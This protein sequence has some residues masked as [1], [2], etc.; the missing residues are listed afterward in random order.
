MNVENIVLGLYTVSIVFLLLS[1]FGLR[2]LFALTWS[3]PFIF[4]KASL[5]ILA[6]LLCL[7]VAQQLSH[8][9][10]VFPDKPIVN[11]SVNKLQDNQYRLK[12]LDGN[13]TQIRNQSEPG[14]QGEVFLINGDQW[15]LEMRM[16]TWSPLL[17]ELGLKPL[18]KLERLNGRYQNLEDEQR[19]P[20]SLYQLDKENFSYNYWQMLLPYLHGTVIHAYYGAAVY[21]PLTDAALYGVFLN[22]GG[23]ELKALNEE[24]KQ[25]L[26]N[27]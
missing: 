27:W 16:L 25:A 10:P 20:R 15:L 11:I 2:R 12:V 3:W 19:F 22:P 18:Y 8:F 7:L 26:I 9:F 6:S 21:A 13:L 24:A 1:L 23:V 5:Y 17:A 14:Q 4:F